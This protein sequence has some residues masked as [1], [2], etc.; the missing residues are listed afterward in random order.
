MPFIYMAPGATTY[1]TF[2]I[3]VRFDNLRAIGWLNGESNGNNFKINQQV[4]NSVGG[5]FVQPISFPFTHK[6]AH[7]DPIHIK[8]GREPD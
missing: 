4:V 1:T 6:K 8:N 2:Y 3:V 7:L 5:G